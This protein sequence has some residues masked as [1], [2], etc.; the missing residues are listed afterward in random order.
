MWHWQSFSANFWFIYSFQDIDDAA[1]GQKLQ[2]KEDSAP[3]LCAILEDDKLKAIFVV[4]DE[5]IIRCYGNCMILAVIQLICVYYIFDIDYPKCYAMLLTLLQ[6][7]VV[8]EM[9]S[10][11]VSKNVIS[12]SN[13]WNQPSQ[14]KN[15]SVLVHQNFKCDL[16]KTVCCRKLHVL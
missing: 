8:E 9:Y 2:S 16:W 10:N 4:G 3:H 6:V 5:A 1:T 13:V 7:L 12:F 14:S 11:Q 15:C